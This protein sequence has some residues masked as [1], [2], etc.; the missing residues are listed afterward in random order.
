[1][2]S[3]NEIKGGLVSTYRLMGHISSPATDEPATFLGK[4][5]ITEPLFFTPDLMNEPHFFVS[6]GEEGSPSSVAAK[7][8]GE[9]SFA[10]VLSRDLYRLMSHIFKVAALDGRATKEG[11]LKT[12]EPHS[13]DTL[14]TKKRSALDGLTTFTRLMSH[15][16]LCKLSNQKKNS[17]PNLKTLCSSKNNKTSSL[18]ASSLKKE[19]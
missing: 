17:A 8:S 15:K 19:I 9:G 1:M 10:E 4:R 2:G 5:Q 12:T 6:P 7:K 3:R 14:A 13:F 16:F 11:G 18:F